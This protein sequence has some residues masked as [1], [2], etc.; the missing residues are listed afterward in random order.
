VYQSFG[1]SRFGSQGDKF[2]D[3][4]ITEIVIGKI[5]KEKGKVSVDCFG[6]WGFKRP[7]LDHWIREVAKSDLPSEKRGSHKIL[8]W[9]KIGK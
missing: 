9:V 4:V 5:L 2:L 3:I 7:M 6:F 8:L 1:K